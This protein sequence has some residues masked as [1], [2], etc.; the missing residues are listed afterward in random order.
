MG[1]AMLR[2]V[3]PTIQRMEY[4]PYQSMVVEKEAS[5]ASEASLSRLPEL[6]AQVHVLEEELSAQRARELTLLD[7]ARR[8]A[9]A[10]G[11]EETARQ[12]AELLQQSTARMGAA[13]EDFRQERDLYFARVEQEVVRLA[14]AIAARILHRESQI[15]PLLLSGAVRV[16]LGQLA[17]STGVRLRVPLA[18]LPMWEEMLRLL[19]NLPLRPRVEGEAGMKA[20]ECRLETELGSVDLGVRAQLAEI[21]RGFFDLLEQRPGREALARDGAAS[22][23][24]EESGNAKPGPGGRAAE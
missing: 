6:E 11:R 3:E 17:E 4:L 21:E 10:Q 15:D 20:G 1:M 14:L 13:L 2:E 5:A 23:A 24:E 12:T 22:P 18:E 7:E 9:L 16:A 8:E 19:P